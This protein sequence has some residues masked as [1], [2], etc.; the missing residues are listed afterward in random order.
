MTDYFYLRKK[1]IDYKGF[2]FNK[3]DLIVSWFNLVK[4][5]QN[6]SA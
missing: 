2:F 4:W 1:V 5:I 3:E 6:V